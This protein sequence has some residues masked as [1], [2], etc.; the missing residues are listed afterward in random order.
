MFVL[1]DFGQL[2]WSKNTASSKAL[3]FGVLLYNRE[4]NLSSI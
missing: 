2:E 3:P 1:P 4:V